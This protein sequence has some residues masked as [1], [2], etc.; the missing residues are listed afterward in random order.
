MQFLTGFKRMS[1]IRRCGLNLAIAAAVIGVGTYFVAPAL[2]SDKLIH[3]K[4]NEQIGRWTGGAFRLRADADAS[5]APGFRVIVSD[6]AFVAVGDVD[7]S[8][9]VTADAVVAPLRI[10][11]LLLGRVEIAELVLVQ[12][13]IDLQVPDAPFV[14][15][16]ASVFDRNALPEQIRRLGDVVVID[17]TLHLRDAAGAR[18]VSDINLRLSTDAATNA[19]AMQGG[20]FVG[21]RHVRIGL[22]VDD[23]RG[24][25]SD[26]GTYAKLNVRFGRRQDVEHADDAVANPRLPYD[27]AAYV[28]QFAAT[29]GFPGQGLGSITAEGNFSVRPHAVSITDAAFSF[30]RVEMEGHMRARAEGRPVIAQLLELPD[31]VAAFVADAKN[32]DDGRWVDIPVT[33][34]WLDG[35]DMD[36]AL[37][38]GTTAHETPL[39][40]TAAV[41]LVVDD[42]TTS[43]KATGDIEG[44]GQMHAAVT[45]DHRTGEQVRLMAFG[46]VD[47]ISVGAISEFLASLGPP[48]LIGTAQ[49]PDGT[50]NG[51]F[52]VTANGNAIGQM[53][54]SLNGSVTAQL[55]D[56][57]L[58]GADL[59]ATL[60]TLRRGREFMTEDKGPLIPTA[61]RTPFDQLNARVDLAQGTASVSHVEIFGDQFGIDMLGEVELAEGTMNVGGNIVLLPSPEETGT[62][63]L[64]ALVEL[65]FGVG[66]TV[67][68]PVVAP[69]VPNV[70]TAWV[71]HDPDPNVENE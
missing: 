58:V 56:G 36:I 6:P 50:M 71:D 63:S 30:G 5:V 22:Q 27:I 35:L 51:A 43:F 59:V 15:P 68:A 41:A 52:D 8:P 10:L 17:G 40:D 65:P 61:G 26:V 14:A 47:S 70:A 3:A 29:F 13:H 20:V 66:G 42:E 12:P 34:A 46:H 18:Q 37:G 62:Q 38:W 45:L 39:Q 9:I 64:D 48:P 2:V 1:F 11:P 32:M 55:K 16:A 28:R 24:F 33:M 67:F 49:M 57:S 60:E 54:D 7:G 44:L 21:S 69:G 19:V 53:L 31:A 4:V 23:L 25:V